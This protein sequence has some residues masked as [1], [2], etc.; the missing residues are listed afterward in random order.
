LELG[1]DDFRSAS[2]WYGRW[3]ENGASGLKTMEEYLTIAEVADR[4]KVRRTYGVTR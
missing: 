3:N 1:A 2:F 4:L